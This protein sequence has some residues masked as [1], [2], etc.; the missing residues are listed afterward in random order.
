MQTYHWAL[1]ETKNQQP[2]KQKERQ[3]QMK[4]KLITLAY[5]RLLVAIT[6]PIQGIKPNQINPAFRLA[7]IQLNNVER[8]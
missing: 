1:V 8:R 4:E 5:L 3:T 7:M 6:K 2:T